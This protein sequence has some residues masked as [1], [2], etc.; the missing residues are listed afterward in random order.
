MRR[1]AG[2]CLSGE[3]AWSG[4]S[5]SEKALPRVGPA[6]GLQV[7]D[8]QGRTGSGVPDKGTGLGA[9]A[10]GWP[11]KK[12]SSV[13]AGQH[14]PAGGARG[15][16]SSQLLVF[17]PSFIPQVFIGLLLHARTWGWSWKWLLALWSSQ[18]GRGESHSLNNHS[19]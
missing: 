5:C 10:V 16:K 15:C 12:C 18:S 11:S 19:D 14:T 3:G 1:A 2:P 8:V 6:A 13:N 17:L 7:S 9:Q 4:H